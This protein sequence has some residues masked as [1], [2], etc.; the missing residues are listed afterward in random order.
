MINLFNNSVEIERFNINSIYNDC[1]TQLLVKQEP[2]NELTLNLV[3]L[4]GKK[5]AEKIIKSLIRFSFYIEPVKK[6][7][8]E[9]TK[10][11]VRWSD[12]LN[13]DP[14]FSSYGDCL[15]IFEILFQSLIVEL[16]NPDNR[17]LIKSMVNKTNVSYEIP[18][19][20]IT[21]TAT[22][23]HSIEN[24]SWCF[25]SLPTTVVKLRKFLTD[26]SKHAYAS[27]FSGVYNKINTKT[28]LTDRVLTGAHKTNREKRWEC[29]P[30]SVHFA[31]RKIAWAIEYKL[32]KQVCHFDGF[33]QE[34]K[35]LMIDENILVFDDGV[36]KCPI[37][38]EP[39]SFQLLKNEIENKTHGKSDFQVGHMNPLK[40]EA[41][42]EIT[43]HTPENISWISEQGNRI[44]G[45]NSVEFIRDFI[46]KVSKNYR[47]AGFPNTDET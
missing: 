6:P 9:T 29:H 19:D 17:E 31:L 24:I 26:S 30:N 39:L 28:Y 47:E 37:T 43:G 36:V 46:I 18:I 1:F 40:A 11:A 35:Q 34:L 42:E 21:S 10:F 7:K 5:D 45:S 13:E 3:N 32:I 4:V 23:I 15:Q 33:P 8:I 44:Q 25:N 16:N 20:Y 41:G 12:E 22:P 2:F 14:R 27:F 38:L